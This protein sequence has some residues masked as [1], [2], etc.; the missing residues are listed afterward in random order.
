MAR[1]SF[2]M[3]YRKV[4][5]EIGL[6]PWFGEV[7]NGPLGWMTDAILGFDGPLSVY[8]AA[9]SDHLLES[10]VEAGAPETVA[11]ELK[12]PGEIVDRLLRELQEH[13]LPDEGTLT[14]DR[15]RAFL[16]LSLRAVRNPLLP[17]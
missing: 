15:G 13:G 16:A 17:T 11:E 3:V 14:G 9:P 4:W 6:P 2:I 10:I 12:V 1:L 8:S 5:D 7:A